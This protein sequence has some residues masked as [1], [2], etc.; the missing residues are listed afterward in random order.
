MTLLTSDFDYSLP[1]ELVAQHPAGIRDSSRLMVLDRAS[2]DQTERSFSDL[3]DY[4]ADG[5]VLVVNDTRVIPARLNGQKR[6]SGGAVELL[7]LEEISPRHWLALAGGRRLYA[8]TELCFGGDDQEFKLR[9]EIVDVHDGALREVRFDNDLDDIL[10]ALGTVPLPPYIRE[11][12]E[13]SERYQTIFSHYDGSAASPTAGLHFTGDLMLALRAKG[14]KLARCTLHI[15]LDTFL[16][17]S[18]ENLA[19][20]VIHTEWARL[21]A[22]N[23]RVINDAK[24][25]GGKIVAVGTT[26]ARTLETAA[27]RSAGH[28]DSLQQ[29]SAADASALEPSYCP[30]RPVA[31]VDGRTDLFI[32]PG[33]RFRVVD[34]LVTNFHLPRSTLL[35][36][37]SAFAGR[38]RI[39]SAYEGAVEEGY[40]FYSFG[41]AMLII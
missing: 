31:A 21:D 33:Y 29:I 14:V 39:L 30:W 2:A 10:P 15:G 26:S 19:D 7:L 24:L 3:V 1:Q 6:V 34:A 8:G 38:E 35:M 4:L 36:L 16:P 9:A 12:L 11:P 32:Y 20:H 28:K 17:V 40:R 27:L 37:V 25:A 41:D 5:D 18:E 23:A 22:D 13:D